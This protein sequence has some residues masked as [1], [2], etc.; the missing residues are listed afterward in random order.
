MT[1]LVAVALALGLTVPGCGDD[2]SELTPPPPATLEIVEVKVPTPAL[3]GSRLILDTRG[4]D[5]GGVPLRLT[6]GTE[7]FPLL[8]VLDEVV[9]AA[10][11]ALRV[12]EFSR[13]AIDSLGGGV[14]G[15]RLTL[16][17]G[18]SQSAAVP[19]VV[20]IATEL[21]VTLSEVSHGT[22]HHEDEVIVRGD[23][24][25][26]PSEGTIEAIATG[27]FTPE[28]GT[29]YSL[30]AKLPVKLT[31]SLDRARGTMRLVT[32][33]G[34]AGPGTFTG[35]V[36]LRSTLI[37]G[38]QSTSSDLPV[39]FDFQRPALFGFTPDTVALGQIVQLDGAGLLGAP[40]RFDE[41]T[42][43]RFEGELIGADGSSVPFGPAELVID[44]R[45]GREASVA[46]DYTIK[47]K[48]LVSAFFQLAV[49][50]FV[51]TVTPL[52]IKST[53]EVLGEPAQIQF[54]LAGVRQIAVVS[55]LP[56][57]YES[58]HR[59]GL[60]LA[61]DQVTE[62]I[63]TRMQSI[64]DDYAVDF[65]SEPPTDFLPNAVASI[66]V[67]GPDPNGYGVFGYD[68]SPGK[69]VGN[70]RLFDSVGGE[71]AEIQK[72]G[73]PGYGGVFIESFLW[74]STHPN[75]PGPRPPGAPEVDPLFDQMFDPVRGTP[76]TL[77]EAEGNG[78]PVRVEQVQRAIS[79]LANIVGETT[80]HEFGH[81]L[82]LAQPY[83]LKS[84]FHN[85]N[86]GDGCLM[87]GGAFR[88]LGERAGQPG[89]APAV[90][91][92]DAPK[93]LQEILPKL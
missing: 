78:E 60:D 83:G 30:S 11:G 8:F 84:A 68:N 1:R 26:A 90:L 6:V 62:R 37:S 86:P 51:G 52:V 29:A 89:F 21:K 31:E 54:T 58:L 33:L 40:D 57:F 36:E 59:F 42:I 87:D 63:F 38:V 4:L 22:V 82:G 66:E 9:D 18:Q 24:F 55:F 14:H 43:I 92:G 93:Y 64:F 2:K 28:G 34:G 12:F 48:K 16:I 81:S 47:S 23:G 88:T 71:N 20:T 76:A 91:C 27:D 3:Q 74:W 56:G 80:A 13:I 69:D 10:S 19:V 25:L 75:L 72:D 44:V 50:R 67:G 79:A 15:L 85:A 45:T 32:D 53:E 65:V 5:S 61:R 49:G 35:T 77:A 17:Q 73:N 7:E 41:A 39:T 46:V 70:L